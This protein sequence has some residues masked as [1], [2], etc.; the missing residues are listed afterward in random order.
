M[1]LVASG[2]KRIIYE[3]YLSTRLG[4]IRLRAETL[5]HF[6]LWKGLEWVQQSECVILEKP[7]FKNTVTY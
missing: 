7:A 3:V 6:S 1:H 2:K 4:G 5:K